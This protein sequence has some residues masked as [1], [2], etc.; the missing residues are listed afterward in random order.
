MPSPGRNTYIR[1]GGTRIIGVRDLNMEWSG[2]SINVTSGEDNGR[3]LLLDAS[4]VET[5]NFSLEGVAKDEVLRDI[6]LGGTT[7]LFTDMDIVFD[8]GDTLAMDMR[9]SAYSEGNPYE[10]A[11]TFSASLEGSGDWT[12]TQA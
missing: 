12:Y 8:N 5:L 6:I 3:T 9:F 4:G 7:R 10:E 1:R 2:S 11:K